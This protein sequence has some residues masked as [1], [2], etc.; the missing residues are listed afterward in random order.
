M[1]PSHQLSIEL[2]NRE[3]ET[4]LI[5]QRSGDGYINATQLCDAANKK[6]HQYVRQETTGMYL[7]A[8][9]IKTDIPQSVLVQ[10]YTAPDGSINTWVHPKVAIHLAQWLS[11][12][13]AVQVSEWV[14][15]WMNGKNV[16]AKLPYHLER[17]MINIYKIPMGYFSVLQEMTNALV[18]PLEAQGYRLPEHMMPD[19]SHGRLL[20]KRLREEFKFNTNELPTYNHTFPDGRE[21]DAKL[22][23]LEYLGFFRKLLEKEW[24]PMA[25]AKYFKQ[26]DPAALIALDK[27]MMIGTTT[28]TPTL[29]N[30]SAKH[31]KRA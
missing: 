27:V 19:I 16:P 3:V 9:S 4:S 7:R 24:F 2:I 11:A 29:P 8:L 23:P 12:D 1:P 25:A 21:V 5:Q 20:C 30:N 18:A 17:H 15:D 31:K 10:E 13:F 26:R 22:Y 14:F 6:W 28:P